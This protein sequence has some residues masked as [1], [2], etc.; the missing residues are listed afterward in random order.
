MNPFEILD[1]DNITELTPVDINELPNVSWSEGVKAS[2]IKA[3]DN[4]ASMLIGERMYS[5]SFFKEGYKT[6]NI[7]YKGRTIDE[8]FIPINDR[9]EVDNPIIA[10]DDWE[11]SSYYRKGINWHKNMTTNEAAYLATSFDKEYKLNQTISDSNVGFATSLGTGLAA[12]LMDPL[13]VGAGLIPFVGEARFAELGVIGGATAR[14]AVQAGAEAAI[15][16][17]FA[18]K[19]AQD[20]QREYTIEDS[21]ANIL[22]SMGAGGIFGGL[23]GT[24]K[25][26]KLSKELDV[27][28]T[29]TYNSPIKE[30]QVRDTVDLL[31]KAILEDEDVDITTINEINNVES[32]ASGDKV[33]EVNYTIDNEI[34]RV[35]AIGDENVI[36]LVE[37]RDVNGIRSYMDSMENKEGN[38]YSFL[39]AISNY[40]LDHDTISRSYNDEYKVN[41][42]GLLDE[43][44]NTEGVDFDLFH[45]VRGYVLRKDLDSI[46]SVISTEHTLIGSEKESALNN[47][48]RVMED[49]ITREEEDINIKLK[50][51]RDRLYDQTLDFTDETD[52]LF[53]SAEKHEQKDTFSE[54]SDLMNDTIDYRDKGE[55]LDWSPDRKD[56]VRTLFDEGQ[57]TPEL[58]QEDIVDG[59]I[60]CLV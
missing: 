19:S 47:I 38:L 49:I 8:E 60:K 26:L 15:I 12:G 39:D 20:L 21:V 52:E 13:N 58:T 46:E 14:G 34:E 11:N 37:N 40:I 42:V 32:I 28:D 18:Y 50:E 36:E 57:I 51:I 53:S 10:Q 41:M 56:Y 23:G 25:S 24:L 45:L 5:E 48:A 16:E 33:K 27:P 3:Y 59:L 7:K 30:K 55:S 54:F 43:F 9:A 17:P 29:E 6:K 31:T 2:F 44:K 1:R 35:R 4:N 22:F